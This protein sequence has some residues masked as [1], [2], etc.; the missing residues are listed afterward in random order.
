MNDFDRSVAALRANGTKILV[1][2][3]WGTVPALAIL[4]LVAGSAGLLVTLIA[5]SAA[6]AL[7]TWWVHRGKTTQAARIAL[8]MA[9]TVAPMLAVL[10]LRGHPWQ[11]DMHMAFF[12]T[13]AML[14]LLCDW[15]PIVA[16]AAIIV[17]HHLGLLYILPEW[18]FPG[19]GS[20]G[21][22]LLHGLLVIAEC[23]VLIATVGEIGRLTV[24]LMERQQETLAA[25]TDAEAARD[26][27]VA[28]LAEREAAQRAADAARGAIAATRRTAESEARQR[29]LA[30]ADSI[31]AALGA[32]ARDLRSAAMTLSGRGAEL[33]GV[34]DTLV[35]EARDLRQV[36]QTALLSVGM[37]AD[38]SEELADTIGAVGTSAGEVHRVADDT[39][40]AIATLGPRLAALTQETGA[41]RAI[42][43]LVVAISEQ[44]NLLA[45]NAT[46]EAARSGESGRGFAVVANE[47]K[48][49]ARQTS[50]AATEIAY[51]LEAI[52]GAATAFVDA[53]ATATAS[54]DTIHHATSGIAAAVQQQGATT[55]LIAD[56]ADSVRLEIISTDRL[57]ATIGDA[58]DTNRTV[59]DNALSLALALDH[60]AA[61]LADRVETLLVDLR[62]A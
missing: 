45:I 44:S 12:V 37:V 9:S 43:D 29:R 58:A 52:D 10:M 35:H 42:L 36:A 61:Q 59:A 51:K 26:A 8:G 50:S 56:S 48:A 46:I 7:P 17:V 20:L 53:I 32:I 16:A 14:V 47:M 22:V 1:G 30:T 60:H 3:L 28:A 15:R 31:D 49:M 55:R 5:A 62:A 54:V 38:R 4:G 57:S 19:S 33:S 25:Q 27:A 18:V 34:A 41:A 23:A 21:R 24:A 11:M 13:L 6:L 39:S 2:L 40:T